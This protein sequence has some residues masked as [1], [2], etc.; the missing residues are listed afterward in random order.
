MK[1][2]REGLVSRLKVLKQV[3]VLQKKLDQ[4]EP[5]T[6]EYFAKHG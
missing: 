5:Q 4:R 2:Q 6:S 1:S 3:S